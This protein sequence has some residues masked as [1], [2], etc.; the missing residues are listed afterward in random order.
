MD[1]YRSC[2]KDAFLEMCEDKIESLTFVNNCVMII[3]H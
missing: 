3:Y 2:N 1:Y